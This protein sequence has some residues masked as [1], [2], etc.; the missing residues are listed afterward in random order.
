MHPTKCIPRA[1]LLAAMERDGHRCTFV[2]PNGRCAETSEL[3]IVP[4]EI[5]GN[6]RM[7]NLRTLCAVHQLNFRGRSRGSDDKEGAAA[8]L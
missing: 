4:V 2:G 5:D 7:V 1:V 3:T 8:P 6:A